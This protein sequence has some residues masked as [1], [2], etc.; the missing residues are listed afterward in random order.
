MVAMKAATATSNAASAAAEQVVLSKTCVFCGEPPD[1]KTK[2]HVVPRW[3]IELTGDPKREWRIG[4]RWSETDETKRERK[5]A[6]DQFHFPACK[7][8][9]E[10]YS[11]LEERAKNSVT[12]LIAAEPL[13]ASAWDDLL[14]WFDKVRIGIW[15]GMRY[16]NKEFGLPTPHFHI[17]DRIGR[18]DRL[19]LVYRITKEHTGLIMH[20]AGDLTFLM[21]PSWLALTVNNLIFI[22]IS[23]EYLL[24]ARMGFPFPSKIQEN[25]HDGLAVAS[26]FD[27]FF[28]VKVPLLRFAFPTA[29]IAVYQTIMMTPS[30]ISADGE[31]DEQ[32]YARLCGNPFVRERLIPGSECRSLIHS[33]NGAG[34]TTHAPKDLILERELLQAEYRH[35][36]DYLRRYFEFRQHMLKDHIAS[37]RG[38]HAKAL[39]RTANKFN[40]WAIQHLQD[41]WAKVDR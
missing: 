19:V 15:L 14:D 25:Q 4:V 17:T 40:I 23:S 26:D 10:A 20:G 29:P 39:I 16:F 28:R 13:T 11:A 8:C 12:K 5:F 38:A 21:Q 34:V 32:N 18:K 9:N 3:L 22:N 7:V 6:A 37:G 2:E 33:S 1:N 27:A 41:E 24:A 30:K 36:I 31:D 35:G